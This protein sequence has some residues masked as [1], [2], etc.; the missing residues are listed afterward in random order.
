MKQVQFWQWTLRDPS[1]GR[2]ARTR[3]KMT[4]EEARSL[5]AL[6]QRVDGTMEC[7]LVDMDEHGWPRAAGVP[8]RAPA[9]PGDA[10]GAPA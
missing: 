1:T 4:V 9:G 3:W 10:A 2:V 6:A 5:D 7:R 8:A